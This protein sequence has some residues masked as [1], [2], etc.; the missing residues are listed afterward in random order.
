MNCHH[1]IKRISDHICRI[2]WLPHS[3]IPNKGDALVIGMLGLY[4]QISL[5]LQLLRQ[6]KSPGSNRSSS[7]K[8]SAEIP[9][10]GVKL[11]IQS[12]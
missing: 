6:N 1:K 9:V 5:V 10:R 7:P 12:H 4:S 11:Y 3:T 8:H 2:C